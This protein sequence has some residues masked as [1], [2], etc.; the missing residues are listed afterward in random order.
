MRSQASHFVQAGG[1]SSGQGFISVY[2]EE[3]HVILEF[4]PFKIK[5]P[6]HQA[7]SISADL[8][9]KAMM[10]GAPRVA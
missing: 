2:V 4:G 10:A 6:P 5:M 9:I 7:R 8:E 3:G 1:Q